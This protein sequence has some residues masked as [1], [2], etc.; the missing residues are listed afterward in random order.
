[1]GYADDVITDWIG[2]SLKDHPAYHS[3]GRLVAAAGMVGITYETTDR[4]TSTG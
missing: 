2:P 1:M 3:W 4:T